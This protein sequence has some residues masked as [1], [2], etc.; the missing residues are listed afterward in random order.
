MINRL[1]YLENAK[2]LA[3]SGEVTVDITVRDPITRLWFYMS[4]T[5]GG[6]TNAA[7]PLGDCIDAAELIDGSQVLWSLDGRQALAHHTYRLG[8]MPKQ[9]ISELPSN[10]NEW[11]SAMHFGR[12]PGDPQYAFDPTRFVNPQ[13]RFKWNLANVNAVGASG[14]L[15][16]TGRLTVVAEVLDGVPAPLGMLCAKEHYTWVTS[17]GGVE[18]ID[19][20]RDLHYRAMMVR[21]YKAAT[22]TNGVVSKL[23][24]SCD[25]GKVIPFEI[26]MFDLLFLMAAD[27]RVFDYRH[28][29]HAGSGYTLYPL[30]KYEEN[31]ELISEDIAD[32]VFMYPNYGYGSQTLT[33]EVAGVDYSP[34]CNIGAHVTGMCPLGFVW[35]PFGQPDD[36]STWFDAP[37]FGS[38]RLEATGA[39]AT[40]AGEIVLE[41]LRPY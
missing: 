10:P 25:G 37:S 6:T 34:R 21:A 31:L 1:V 20:P 16:A 15:T 36:P 11:H 18:Y 8:R 7:N 22:Y 26:D 40:G 24:L 14:Y 4:A 32:A 9:V 17:S 33:L 23:K 39:V 3:D 38:L 29:F 28:V 41:Q 27:G 13:F 30:L 2:V 35:L 12:F 19:L 5:N